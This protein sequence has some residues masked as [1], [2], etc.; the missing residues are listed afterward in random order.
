M[1]QCTLAIGPQAQDGISI[2]IIII[3]IAVVV[4]NRPQIARKRLDHVVCR[5]VI[6][7]PSLLAP[8]HCV[9]ERGLAKYSRFGLAFT[10]QSAEQYETHNHADR[11]GSRARRYCAKCLSAV[12]R[13]ATIIVII[14]S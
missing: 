11:A 8:S 14:R 9:A 7:R 1:S 10:K 6:R 12:T 3:V 13:Q 5:H 4:I 2:I